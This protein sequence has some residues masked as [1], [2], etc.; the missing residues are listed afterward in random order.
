[1]ALI[2]KK[3]VNIVRLSGYATD[4]AKAGQM[5][6]LLCKGSITS[7]DPLF[8]TYIEGIADI[9]LSKAGLNEVFISNFLILHHE[10]LS[11]DIYV[12]DLPIG[13][14][15][16]SKRRIKKGEVVLE[17]DIA[18]IGRLRFPNIEI[19]DADHV[20]FCLKKG[21]KF[22]YF[23][24][25]ANGAGS[26]YR[27]DMDKMYHEFGSLYKKLA[28]DY[29]FKTI[30]NARQF[31]K[32]QK[33]GWFPY[34]ELLG[35]DFKNLSNAYINNKG[36]LR[37]AVEKLIN[38]FD[39][40]RIRKIYSKWWSNPIFKGKKKLLM[41]GINSYLH[42]DKDGF[43]TCIKTL[44]PE[45]QGVLTYL[46]YGDT[47]KDVPNDQLLIEH[48][49]IRGIKRTGS[50]NPLF[51]PEYFASFLENYLFP[52]FDL[53]K[54]DI[55]LSRHTSGH[56]IAMPKEYTKAKALQAILILDQ[57]YFFIPINKNKHEST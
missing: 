5:V 37:E 36:F 27:I 52:K 35:R 54:K 22:G 17:S 28:Y 7:D 55:K 1:M 56:G 47:K 42:N 46:F 18:D 19:K 14:E 24:D 4:N 11:V 45:I 51:F 3:L 10:D 29:L 39:E 2:Y 16:L 8:Y 9:F 33:D 31:A 21:W 57:I 34:V 48:L 23:F 41:A 53:S 25:C 15:F 6:K 26:L 43:I 13:I 40:K 50:P 30:S 38:G 32:M 44:Y 12:N 49:K 20:F